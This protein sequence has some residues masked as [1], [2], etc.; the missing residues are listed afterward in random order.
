MFQKLPQSSNELCQQMVAECLAAIK[1]NTFIDNY[2]AERHSFDG[3]DRSMIFDA[4]N[5]AIQFRW[6]YEN[7]SKIHEAF[8]FLGD[9]YSKSMILHVLAYR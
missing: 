6:F 3:V 9:N 1:L 4:N 5:F 7:H 8:E 2:D